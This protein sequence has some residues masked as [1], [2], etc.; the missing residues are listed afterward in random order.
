MTAFMGGCAIDLRQAA[1]HG[2]AVIDVFAMWGGIEISVPDT[3]TVIDRVTPIMGG[4]EDSTRAPG[5]PQ[6]H[7][8]IVRG[9]VVMGG[10]EIKN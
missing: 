7:T 1:I 10:I 3:W 8:L 6:G 5:N 2:E 4:V 9:V